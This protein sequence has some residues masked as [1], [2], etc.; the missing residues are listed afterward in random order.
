MLKYGSAKHLYPPRKILKTPQINPFTC[1]NFMIYFTG[2]PIGVVNI[3]HTSFDRLL[4]LPG[5]HAVK[6][7]MKKAKV[8]T[9][10]ENR[11]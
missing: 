4:R 1:C 11:N 2:Y 8:K 10:K 6:D 7:E 3:F 9:Q 5:A